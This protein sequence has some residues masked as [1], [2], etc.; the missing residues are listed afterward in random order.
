MEII[1]RYLHEVGRHLPRKLRADV[2]VELRTLLQET[3]EERARA[4]PRAPEAS[5]AMQV[6]REFGAPEEVAA[7][8]AP[9]PRYLI[10]PRFYSTYLLIVKIIVIVLA[11]VFAGMVA[12]AA[13]A[14][15]GPVAPLEPGRVL[16]MLWAFTSSGI[17]NL[18]ILT[19][20]F[21]IVE[22][23]Q[24]RPEPEAPPWDPSELPAVDDPDQIS[25]AG[26]V[27]GMYFILAFAVLFNFYPE[28]VG[29]AG[30][31]AGQVTW[32]LSLLRPEF[33]MHMPLINLWWG[34]DFALALVVLRHGRW[35]RETRWAEFGLG[36]FGAVILVL[37]VLGPPVFRY[38]WLA[39]AVLKG[40]ILIVAIESG[41]RLY[42][43]LTRK[44]AGILAS[45]EPVT[46]RESGN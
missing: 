11:A 16:K 10:G 43:M 38:D 41:A 35:R 4:T 37:I 39:K 22:R 18:A 3:L 13:I 19:L 5:L 9:Q 17:F 7:R 25:P 26:M 29:I 33:T 8:Y 45:A 12:V 30:F 32:R 15:R 20:V 36:L 6:L 24:P 40:G 34:L 14:S 23:V 31:S 28:W 21:A 44:P 1:D 46:S 42:R 27:V 2:Q